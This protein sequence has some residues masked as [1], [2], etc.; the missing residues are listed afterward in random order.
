MD[1]PQPIPAAQVPPVGRSADVERSVEWLK[2]G[3]AG[4]LRA[5]GIW[6]AAT[7][8]ALVLFVVL[9]Q[10]PLIGHLAVGF[11]ALLFGAC[12]LLASRELAAGR[13]LDVAAVLAGFRRKARPLLLLA[14]GYVAALIGIALISFAIGGTAAWSGNKVGHL[15]GTGIALGG[16]LLAL[17]VALALLVPLFMA[18]WF[19]PSLV[20]FTS[21]EPLAALRASFGACLRNLLPLL[22]LGIILFVL[23]F[24]ALIPFG[25]GLVLLLPVVAGAQ[26]ASYAEIFE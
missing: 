15:A 20:L 4:F 10:L 3:W 2:L 8:A 17:L 21:L 11:C 14:G 22:V 6:V 18:L 23:S 5:P 7:L 24:V 25:L 13:E 26:Y 9:S 1:T 19:A 16:F 12:L